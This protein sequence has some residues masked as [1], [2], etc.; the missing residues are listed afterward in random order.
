[1]GLKSDVWLPTLLTNTSLGWKR[2]TMENTLAYYNMVI[3]TAVKS[4]KGLELDRAFT[5]KMIALDSVHGPQH[6]LQH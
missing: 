3:I 2:L 5:F 1:M 6:F 4:F